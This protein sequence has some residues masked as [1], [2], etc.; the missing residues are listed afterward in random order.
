MFLLLSNGK[1]IFG[2][3]LVIAVVLFMMWRLMLIAAGA[4]DMYG[5]L[6]ATGVLAH[7]ALQVLLNI[8]VVTNSVPATGIPFPFIS[9]GG[10]SLLV[11]MAEMGIALS[12]SKYTV[13]EVSNEEVE[14]I[15]QA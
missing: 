11:L 6:V 8:A 1:P 2:G 12:V 13:R 5:G 7:I 14:Q 3:I 10:S 15:Y 4:P 9:Y